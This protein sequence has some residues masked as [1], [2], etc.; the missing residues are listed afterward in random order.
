MTFA[1]AGFGFERLN[2]HGSTGAGE[3]AEFDADGTRPVDI[4][5][6]GRQTL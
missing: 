5:I 1:A 3:R 6:D 2:F 4:A